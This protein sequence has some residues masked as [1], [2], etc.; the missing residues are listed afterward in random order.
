MSL[1]S[2][3]IRYL[4]SQLG[5]S[6]QRVADDLQITRGRYAK[7]EDGVSEPPIELLIRM[8]RYYKASIDLLVTV[9]LIKYSL[10]EILKLPD[11]RIL[12]PLKVDSR[13]EN[14]IEIVPYKAS[15]GYLNGYADPEYIENL[16][17]ISLPFL[18]AG[19]YRA[20]P[21][22]GGSMPPHPDGSFI[23]GRYIENA[24]EL[25]TGLT[26]VFIT[27]SEGITY[28]RLS[29]ILNDEIEVCPDNALYSSYKIQ[30]SDIFE[31]WEFAC[32][33]ATKEFSKGELQLDNITIMRMLSELKDEVNRLRQDK[34][35]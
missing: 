18:S 10:S 17:T 24:S 3:N 27:R 22:D 6:Q 1:L 5:L 21:A 13:G 35:D 16:K 19:K 32:S 25:K 4:R 12:L 30:L 9:N 28:K 23:V 15:M 7:Y 31:I 26:Y 11:N 8:S 29:A 20:F 14:K 33:I 2:E 34:K